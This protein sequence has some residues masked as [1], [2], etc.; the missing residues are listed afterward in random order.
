MAAARHS[1]DLIGNR[2]RLESTI[3]SG[4]MADV[5]RATDLQLGR[6]VAV[7]L[8]RASVVDD[9]IVTE[10]FRREA[11]A[12]ARLTHPNIVPVYDCVEED[13]QVALIMRL[14]EGKSLRELLDEATD[15]DQAGML[16]VHL[17]VHIGRAIAAALSKAHAENIVHRDI[18]PG[19]ILIMQQGEVLLTD[20]GIAKPLKSSKEDGTDL[21]RVDIMMGT[22]K[23]LSPEQVQGRDL[24]GRADMYSLGL[25]LYE[26]QATAVARLQ[27]DPTPL[28]GI[29]SDVPSNVIAVIN[30]M[31]RRKPEHRYADCNEVAQALESAIKNVHDA[32]TPV[33]G[34]SPTMS[35]PTTARPRP[36]LNDPLMPKKQPRPLSIVENEDT[37]PRPV[38]KKDITPRGV[39]RAESSLPRSQQT[40]TKRNYIPIALLLV[41]ALVMSVMLWRGLQNTKSAPGATPE[42]V[43]D[44]VV[45]PVSVVGLRSYDP[46]GD[47][48]QEN[49]AMIP[50]LTDNN[51]ATSWTTVCYGNQ[52]FGSKG[53]VGVIVQLSGI[54][55]GSL[56][57]TFGTA[58]WNAEVFVSTSE[59]IP[60]TL[61]GWG[62]RVANSNG[63]A[64]GAATFDVAT[65][66]RNVLLY[67]R[68]AGRSTSCSNSNPYKGML[69][70]LSFTSGK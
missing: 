25:V 51:P 22:A 70:D 6:L 4:G 41:A 53:G 31:L 37:P 15:S 58:P 34:L 17:T 7:K 10:R 65:P 50:N 69:S 3:A 14:I 9:P 44:V 43:N 20:F 1:D 8:L 38:V 18:K 63:A 39:A 68:E 21:T 57:A 19:N 62:V 54:G 26:C 30:K 28:T 52:Y 46:N 67:M 29:R 16:S 40:S 48:G 11:R 45:G 64:P 60:T 33:D 36:V 61:D 47:D 2:Y 23:Y 27:R 49:E 55:I 13:G 59:A 66:G 5:W 35:A 42:I 12:L 56:A 32:M 24:D